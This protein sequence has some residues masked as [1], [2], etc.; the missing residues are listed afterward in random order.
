MKRVFVAVLLTS[1]AF[2]AGVGCKKNVAPPP[3]PEDTRPAPPPDTSPAASPTIDISASPTSVE[4]GGQTTLRWTSS[5][6]TSVVID[7]G[8]GNVQQNGS[9][10]VSPSE[11]IT[12]TAR[13]TGAPGTNDASDSV[14]V[15]VTTRPRTVVDE[16]IDQRWEAAVR[17]G[18][19]GPVF[20]AYDKA[21]LSDDARRQLEKNA[22]T[23]RNNPDFG[24]VV[25]EGH[26]DERGTEEYNLALGDR[27]AQAARDYLVQLG[28]SSSRLQ[29]ISFGEERPFAEGSNEA[30]WRLNRRAHFVRQ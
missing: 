16:S 23:F 30:A 17:S 26:C 29:T 5:N 13:A 8:V 18:D 6:A 2:G 20:F 27:R 1:L 22:A 28:V 15:S 25:I 24:T 7:G 10:V 11:S 14:R 12:Y 19:I 21:E 3:P 9:I 4:R